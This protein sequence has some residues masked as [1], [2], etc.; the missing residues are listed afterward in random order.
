M[1]GE[2]TPSIKYPRKHAQARKTI[3][4]EKR[5]RFMELLFSTGFTVGDAARA[6]GLTLQETLLTIEAQTR[7]ATWL[8]KEVRE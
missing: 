4:L 1:S 2:L 3:P 8:Q 7:V 6:A 5:R